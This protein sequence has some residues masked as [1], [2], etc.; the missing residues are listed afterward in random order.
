[1]PE[2]ERSLFRNAFPL[3]D[4]DPDVGLFLSGA[5]GSDREI[6]DTRWIH[7]LQAAFQRSRF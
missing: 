6:R 4:E 5:I 2:G 1:V 3:D 7:S